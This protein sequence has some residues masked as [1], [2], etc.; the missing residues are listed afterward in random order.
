[1]F[2]GLII[3]L[4]AVVG[5]GVVVWGGVQLLSQRSD[6]ALG[7]GDRKLLGDGSAGPPQ[8]ERTVRDVRVGDIIQ[9]GGADF[10]VEGVVEYDEDGHKWRG[11]RLVDGRVERWLLVGLERGGAV[12]LRLLQEDT[13]VHITGYPSEKIVVGG[14]T[15]TQEKRGTATAR[16]VGDA[17]KLPITPDQSP[18]SVLRCRWWRYETA[19]AGALVVEQWGGLYRVLSGEVV[20]HDDLEMMPG[21]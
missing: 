5:A 12:S 18:D 8:L 7:A 6:R 16:V 20:K 21:S 3:A 15:F 11:A 17:G 13:D 2:T 19:G 10:L 4:L 9:H 14:T 1:M